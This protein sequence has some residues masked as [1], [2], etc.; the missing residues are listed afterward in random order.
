MTIDGVE[1]NVGKF[2]GDSCKVRKQS[3]LKISDYLAIISFH[4][5]FIAKSAK[6]IIFYTLHF[7]MFDQHY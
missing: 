4:S 6:F 3:S 2:V 7:S 5:I 1:L